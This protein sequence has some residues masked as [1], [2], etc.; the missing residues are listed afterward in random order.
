MVCAFASRKAADRLLDGLV[1]LTFDDSARTRQSILIIHLNSAPCAAV[2][3]PAI[4]CNNNARL[5][6]A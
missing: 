6:C 5:H 2:C 3:N 4:F 1:L